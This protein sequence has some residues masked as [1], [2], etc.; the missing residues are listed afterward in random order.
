MFRKAHELLAFL[1]LMKSLC[2]WNPCW[3]K[4]SVPAWCSVC[5]LLLKMFLLLYV[6]GVPV[7]E[8]FP[9]V[10]SLPTV[11]GVPAVS[12]VLPVAQRLSWFWRPCCCCYFYE[13]ANQTF[14]TIDT[15]II[16]QIKCS[17]IGLAELSTTGLMFLSTGL[18]H[19]RMYKLFQLNRS[20]NL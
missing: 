15:T 12:G 4:L 6:S 8:C 16:G 11:V 10:A 14:Y 7:N 5:P 1:L 9:A 17:A 18:S 19:I 13:V 2:C 3:R 20:E